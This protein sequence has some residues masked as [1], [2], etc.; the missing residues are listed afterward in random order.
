MLAKLRRT[1]AE[2]G[3]EVVVHHAAIEQMDLGRTYRSIFLAGPTF[4][5]I[6]DDATAARALGRIRDHLDPAGAA[7]VPLFIP[8]PVPQR[9]LGVAREHIDDRNRI[10]RFSAIS[11]E[12]DDASRRQT[13]VVRYEVV[14][15]DDTQVIERPW[16]LHWHTQEGFAE[17]AVDAGLRVEAVL[18]GDGSRA[19]SDATEFAFVLRHG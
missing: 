2:A 19:P 8:A 18:A 5:L 12:R 14:D 7:L 9:H 3:I 6:V 16:V 17:L 15:G 4:N 10:L 1:A 13:T 11:A